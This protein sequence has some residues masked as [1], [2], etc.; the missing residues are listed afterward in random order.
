MKI[1]I[2]AGPIVGDRGGVG[3]HTYY[4]LREM[5]AQNR[6]VEFIAYARPGTQAPG[7][8]RSWP[9]RESLRWVEVSKW[10]MGRRG[11][12]DG[13]DLYHGTNF[14]MHTRG[15][16]GGVV[17]IH[18]LWLERFPR[19]STKPFGQRLSSFKTRR[20]AHRARRVITVSEFSARELMELYGLPA[21]QI[22]VI[23]NAVA[24]DFVALHD[25]SAMSGLRQR[26]QLP[27]RGYILFVGGADPRKNHRT[28]LEA[29]AMVRQE[30]SGR[31]L[32]LAGSRTHPFGS[33][34]ETAAACGL[35]DQVLCPGRL[36][37]DDLRLLYSHADLFV[38]PSLYEGFGM[39]VLEAMACE[40]PV[41]TS[42][43]TALREVAG[44]AAILVDPA[45]PRAMGEAMVTALNDE[46][47]RASLRANGL[48]RVQKFTWQTA[49]RQTL[50][51][52][53]AL[54]R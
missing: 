29:A 48:A 18:D 24:D 19:Y 38:F 33:Y 34:E 16:F 10:A 25:D 51:L 28:F 49:A 9:G 3:W 21:G 44:D 36:S 11:T 6:D 23:P 2:D 54:C 12:V 26:I 32:L 27:P 22:A 7:E 52:Y 41:V 8:V 17:T 1:G 35:R 43:S 14:K 30:L 45:N 40:V 31:T 37:Q 39:P 46:S 53:A 5:L 42:N 4:L 20:T 15:R 50:D 47:L 13:L